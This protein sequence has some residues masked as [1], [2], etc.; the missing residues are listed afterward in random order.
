MRAYISEIPPQRWCV[1]A[2]LRVHLLFGWLTSTFVESEFGSQLVNGMR[3]LHP[4]ALVE[5][6]C[7]HLVDACYLRS[8][9]AIKWT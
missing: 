3:S 1:Y 5:A 9:N 4:L 2:N 8:Q 7:S 6:M